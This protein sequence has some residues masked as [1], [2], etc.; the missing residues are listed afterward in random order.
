MLR[1]LCIPEDYSAN[2]KA[3]IRDIDWG[4]SSKK[5]MVGGFIALNANL[6]FVDLRFYIELDWKIVLF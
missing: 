2:S 3:D 4:S 1:I 6:E 5:K